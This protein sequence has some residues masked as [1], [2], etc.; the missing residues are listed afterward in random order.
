VLASA[1]TVIGCAP[2]IEKRAPVAAGAPID[3]AW[4]ETAHDGT[5]YRVDSARSRVELRTGRTGP[6]MHLGHNHVITSNALAGLVFVGNDRSQ[7][8]ADLTLDVESFV[9]DDP[10]ARTAAGAGFES[11]PTA[12]DIAGTRANMLGPATLDATQYPNITARLKPLDVTA[13][14]ANVTASFAILGAAHELQLPAT[15][16]VVGDRLEVTSAFEVAQTALGITPFS[17]LGGALRVA[18]EVDIRVEL[19]ATRRQ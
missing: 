3:F 4:Y 8:R 2:A 10:A 13:G 18:D 1:V 17:A 6:L 5:V 9:V 15:W 16:K 11:V 12:E 19:V 7:S 14:Q